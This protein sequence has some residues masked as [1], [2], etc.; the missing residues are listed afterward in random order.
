MSVI[1][2]QMIYRVGLDIFNNEQHFNLFA[3]DFIDIAN[4]RGLSISI[5]KDEYDGNIIPTS[6]RNQNFNVWKGY[7]KPRCFIQLKLSNNVYLG[8]E[9][10]KFANNI[11]ICTFFCD[12]NTVQ[13]S[14]LVLEN[15]TPTFAGI[16]YFNNINLTGDLCLIQY[17]YIITNYGV[18]CGIPNFVEDQSLAK[19]T[20]QLFKIFLA[21]DNNETPYIIV[22]SGYERDIDNAGITDGI[23]LVDASSGIYKDTSSLLIPYPGNSSWG[24]NLLTPL[25]DNRYNYFPHLYR[26]F[27]TSDKLFN[28]IDLYDYTSEQVKKLVGGQFF[29]LERG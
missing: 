2:N 8:I 20:S 15:S 5:V 28:I 14:P 25:R 12:A 26:K 19:S 4:D 16:F 22:P 18:I 1:K 24:V 11:K 7:L 29:C 9:F 13:T 17:N 6:S 27:T 10:V 21:N 23:L 3:Q